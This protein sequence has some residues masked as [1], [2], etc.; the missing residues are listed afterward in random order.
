MI[1]HDF[2]HLI[3]GSDYFWLGLTLSVYSLGLF[4]NR[5]L[6][7]P[8]LNPLLIGIVSLAAILHHLG[9]DTGRY[10]AAVQPLVLL[11][12]PATVCL[13]VPLYRQLPLLRRY[14]GAVLTGIVLGVLSN[15]LCLLILGRIF[16][17]SRVQ[18][19]TLLPKSIT[20]AIGVGLAEELGGIA[21]ITVA[22]IIVSGIVGNVAASKICSLSG[23]EEPLA[24]GLS[25][26]TSAH[27]LGTVRALEI[28]EVEGAMSGLAIVVA[29]L[30]TVA[31]APVLM[32]FLF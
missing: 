27:A 22:A 32:R 4:L 1:P 14:A 21:D 24:V 28:G 13:A 25:I 16:G 30:L 9:T 5:R 29:G 20:T 7:T 11:M 3:E 18:F 19:A 2:L 6:K 17:L 8:L 15:A 10:G 26:G 23:I 12:T 31:G